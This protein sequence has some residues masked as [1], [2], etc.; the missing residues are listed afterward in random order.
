MN[1]L[2]IDT[3]NEYL[4]L[5]L[6]A[7]QQIY[8][9]QLLAVNRQSEYILPEIDKLLV[10]AAITLNQIDLIAYNQGPG[11]FTGLRI[12][13]SCALGLAYSIDCRLVPIPSFALHATLY[14]NHSHAIIALDARL[15]QV[16][17]AA[18]DLSNW[19]YSI[20]PQVVNPEQLALILSSNP[21]LSPDRCSLSGSG[22]SLYADKF[23]P[24]LAQGFKLSQ[25]A[26]PSAT[27][28]LELVQRELYP[29]VN[30][31]DA[32]LIYLRN[33]VAL[34]LSEQKAKAPNVNSPIS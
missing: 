24:V 26:N 21:E 19:S 32:D 28:M 14:P 33:K 16:Y 29:S 17:L 34:N 9:Q 3:A 18:I 27:T 12:G 8:Q 31:F 10:Q 1:I 2:A 22:F 23:Q 25:T 11:S 15:S 4:S 13:L 7:N 30:V 20:L 5:A 6:L